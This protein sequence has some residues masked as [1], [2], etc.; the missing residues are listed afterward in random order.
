LNIAVG[1]GYIKSEDLLKD[2]QGEIE[3]IES[4]EELELIEQKSILEDDSIDIDEEGEIIKLEDVEKPLP[5][6]HSCRLK[7]PKL[8]QPDSFRRVKRESDGKEYSVIMGRLKGETTMTEQ[9]YRYNKD[10]WTVS[11][12]KKHCKDHN[13]ILFEPAGPSRESEDIE[14]KEAKGELL[15]VK[16]QDIKVTVNIAGMKEMIAMVEENIKLKARLDNFEITLE[17]ELKKPIPKE[18]EK[19]DDEVKFE[20]EVEKKENKEIG[21]NPDEIKS[22]IVQAIKENIKDVKEGINKRIDDN[23]KRATGKVM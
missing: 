10:I 11:Q 21:L 23:F 3:I 13:G 19:P 9:A 8:F 2:L 6:E 5:Q 22:I 20:F 17:D 15:E 4:E 18:E 7:D 14:G 16:E 1:K 12:A